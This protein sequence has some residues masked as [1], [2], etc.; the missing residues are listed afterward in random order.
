VGSLPPELGDSN[1]PPPARCLVLLQIRLQAIPYAEILR[2]ASIPD[3]GLALQL[4]GVPVCTWCRGTPIPLLVPG[5]RVLLI[6][7]YYLLQGYSCTA[8]S[9]RCH[10]YPYY[11]AITWSIGTP[12]QYFC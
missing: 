9:T 6:S 11:P 12:I 5:A 10:G 3:V 8:A 7:Y 2:I 4:L 1:P